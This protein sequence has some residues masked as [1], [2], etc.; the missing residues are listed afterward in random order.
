VTH[1]FFSR[2]WVHSQNRKHCILKLQIVCHRLIT[3]RCAAA[4]HWTVW[5]LDCSVTKVGAR[6]KRKLACNTL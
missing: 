1:N 4:M 5:T 6:R 2:L 3:L